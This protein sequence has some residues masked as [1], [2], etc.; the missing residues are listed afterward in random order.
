MVLYGVALRRQGF[1][2]PQVHQTKS[3]IMKY[4]K[5]FI[6]I[7][8]LIAIIAGVL[9]LGGGGYFGTKQYQKI[10]RE[11]ETKENLDIQAAEIYPYLTG[12]VE[13]GCKD[14]QGNE[15]KGSGSLWN[16]SKIGFAI[17]TNG[18]VVGP[19][20]KAG[21]CYIDVSSVDRNPVTNDFYTIGLYYFDPL[22][23]VKMIVNQENDIAI[24]SVGKIFEEHGENKENLNYSISSLNK[25]FQEMPIGSP[26]SLIGFPV[27]TEKTIMPYGF[28]ITK[29]FRTITNGVISAY[30]TSVTGS[31][32]TLPFVN[33][34]VSAKID[35]GNSGGIAFSK[36]ENGLCVLGI[37]TWLSVG[38]YETQ[39]LVQ[40]IHNFFSQ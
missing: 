10:K 29:S 14:S 23:P 28:N 19:K 33:Y 13:I 9:I 25:C 12:I 16:L 21:E 27:F 34:F 38:N 11:N 22:S 24:Y 4:Q 37:P 20:Y 1:D 17:L 2:F 32:G 35:S 6:Q 36:N 8:L 7:P 26:V 40:N 30:D 3:L 5:G 15:S 31:S 39:G 18:H